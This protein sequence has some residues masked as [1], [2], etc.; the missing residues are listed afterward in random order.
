MIVLLVKCP[1]LHSAKYAFTEVRFYHLLQDQ[2][3][4]CAVRRLALWMA[5]RLVMVCWFVTGCLHLDRVSMSV[6]VVLELT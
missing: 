6:I 5:C 2:F 1:D 3:D 4:E